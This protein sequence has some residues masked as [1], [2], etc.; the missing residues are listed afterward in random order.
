MCSHKSDR[1]VV[2]GDARACCGVVVVVAV[3]GAR[4]VGHED[5]VG[6]SAVEAVEDVIVSP[7]GRVLVI[8]PDSRDGDEALLGVELGEH[9]VVAI[10]ASASLV[11]CG[12]EEGAD[13]SSGG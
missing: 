2:V 12:G 5:D 7:V 11:Y 6:A 8:P 1:L 10:E 9:G 4:G 3:E 13:A